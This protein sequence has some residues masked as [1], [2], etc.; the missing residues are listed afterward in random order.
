MS[1][2]E[3]KRRWNE[4]GVQT[5]DVEH[6][7]APGFG[8]PHSCLQEKQTPTAT[9]SGEAATAQPIPQDEIRHE[10]QHEQL[11]KQE[12]DSINDLLLRRLSS[13]WNNVPLRSKKR[14][15]VLLD[16]VTSINFQ[17]ASVEQVRDWAQA[18]VASGAS[19]HM[20]F[21]FA[22][23]PTP[24]EPDFQ[25]FSKKTTAAKK[26]VSFSNCTSKLPP[27]ENISP[28]TY[29]IFSSNF[30][31][32][33]IVLFG[34]GKKIDT[35][36]MFPQLID[37]CDVPI[38]LLP[39]LEENWEKL[40]L[41]LWAAYV[42]KDD[43]ILVKRCGTQLQSGNYY[44]NINMEKTSSGHTI[45]GRKLFMLHAALFELL[46][47]ENIET[48]EQE[49]NDTWNKL[50][51]LALNLSPRDDEGLTPLAVA[52]LARSPISRPCISRLVIDRIL[53]LDLT[54]AQRVVGANVNTIRGQL[55]L[56]VVLQSGKNWD[57]GVSSIF[58]AY[59][60]A[61]GMTDS[62]GRCPIHVAASSPTLPGWVVHKILQL[63]PEAAKTRDRYG[64][65]PLHHAIGAG[66]ECI[67]AA[68]P[69]AAFT[70]D[71]KGNLPAYFFPDQ[72][73]RHFGTQLNIRVMNECRK[74]A[75]A[76]PHF[77]SLLFMD[78]SSKGVVHDTYQ[79]RKGTSEHLIG[80]PSRLGH[81]IGANEMS[82]SKVLN[83]TILPEL[84]D[85][86]LPP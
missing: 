63:Y 26:K 38:P 6:S 31:F 61:L 65:L 55:P 68:F 64:R 58:Q 70:P 8:R 42:A 28:P 23:H 74:R 18:I 3:N 46:P 66:A 15:T 59:P 36:T 21:S 62:I 29:N 24:F 40:N 9:S 75:T 86:Y 32:S 39:C 51:Q 11:L 37:S 35:L 83:F 43:F 84:L 71:F 44:E 56:H 80:I 78:F 54:T 19:A 22:F 47:D 27:A 49:Y 25:L 52:A 72:H 57:E 13:V 41:L 82:A 4:I 10:I 69:E 16:M 14:R 73:E 33:K 79:D 12:H 81:P 5:G 60:E 17:T 67:Y 7:L 30:D 76:N 34:P 50:L 45:V 53:E 20:L 85:L 77:R 2:Y 48:M 1:S